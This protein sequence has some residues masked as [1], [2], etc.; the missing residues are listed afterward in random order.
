M[1][2]PDASDPYPTWATARKDVV[3]ASLGSSRLWFTIAQG[4]VTEVYYPRIDI[5]QIRDLGFIIADDAGF[6]VELRRHGQYSVELARPGVPAVKIVHRHPRF[7]FTL[8]VCPSP[9]RDVLL[10]RHRLEG[11]ADLRPYAL[12]ATRLGDSAEEDLAW[13][14]SHHGRRVL[15]AEQGPFGLALCAA[16]AD[17]TD[18]WQ[19]CSAG[20]QEASDG[21]QDFNC[22]GRMTWQ[23]DSAGPGAVSLMGELAPEGQLSLG[24]ATSKEA[25]ATLALSALMDDF[26]AEWD[27]QCRTWDAW[28]ADIRRP[29]EL[30]GDLDRML[31][32]SAMVLKVHEDRTYRGA[33]VAS[34]SVPW[35]DSSQSRGGYHLV[36]SRDLVETAG[37]L[38]AMH[39]HHSARDVL[40]YLIATQQEDGHW[41][42]NQW[43]GGTP[44][45]QGVQL[46]EA[47]F[48]VLLAALLREHDALDAIPVRD[49]IVRA[50]RFI[51]REGPATSQDRWEED[52]GINTFTLAVAI[53]ALVE[54]SAYLDDEAR[55]FAL[56][57]ADFWN[58]SLEDW[59][60]V[61]DTPLAEELGIDGHYIRAMP[62]D[63]ASRADAPS[64]NV[65]I[66]NRRRDLDMPASAQ[67]ATDFL[68]LVRYGLRKPDCPWVIDSLKAVDHLL[69]TDT[70]SGPVWHRYNQDG[71]GEHHDGRPFDG[72]GHGRGWPLLTGE[73]GH[74]ALVAGEDP[75]AYLQ[76]MMAM[77]GPQGMIPEQVWDSS[78]IAEHDLQP[79]KPTGS[80]MPLVWAHSEFIKLCYSR[81]LGRP[82]DRPAATWARYAGERPTIDYGFWGPHARPATLQAGKTLTIVLAAPACVHWGVNGWHDAKDSDTRDSG[83]GL[84]F[85]DLPVAELSAGQTVQF[86][87]LWQDSQQWEDRDYEVRIV[88][89]QGAS[90]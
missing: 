43:L 4:I 25:A 72:T 51:A 32:V 7:T 3:G 42:Q 35:G 67:V 45:W 16:H 61:T 55:D 85:V 63:V 52:A 5:P 1:K 53:A 86:T 23:Y 24:L 28:F 77:A 11:D 82:V 78:P 87:F 50:L 62:A 19:R 46:D 20:C 84:H 34:L 44:F 40:R 2:A 36:W 38:V 14:A 47:A 69:K 49:M 90:A 27:A 70:P 64:E 76:A 37:A 79:G 26:T 68:Q 71:Y 74:Y 58:A 17:G 13:V 54:G 65:P 29:E 83:L 48:P 75:L 33:T 10:L 56:R 22:N 15:W 89:R 60:F 8:E 41:L 66:K 88:P 9:S 39:A 31:A 80:A 21:W 6:W 12:L 30:A 81:V 73:R 59:T 57:L 18:A